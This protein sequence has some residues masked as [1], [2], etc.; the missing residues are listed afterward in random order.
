M[1][2]H[3][4]KIQQARFHDFVLNFISSSSSVCWVDTPENPDIETSSIGWVN[5]RDEAEAEN[6]N[7][8]IGNIHLNENMMIETDEDSFGGQDN[9]EFRDFD[10]GYRSPISFHSRG[11]INSWIKEPE[12]HDDPFHP[13]VPPDDVREQDDEPEIDVHNDVNVDGACE[14][15]EAKH[16]DRT[17]RDESDA[18]ISDHI[19]VEA[20]IDDVNEM[21]D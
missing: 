8:S 19:E 6:I 1:F 10:D 12:L 14:Y 7:A 3:L 15:D 11:S 2:I 9:L 17:R 18:T 13:D 16:E 4:I 5:P 20:D 21:K